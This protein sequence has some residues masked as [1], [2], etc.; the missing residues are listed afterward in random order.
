M[1]KKKIALIVVI[2]VVAVIGAYRIIEALAPA[3]VAE[4]APVNVMVATAELGSINTTSLITGRI[5][6]VDEAVVVPLVAGEVSSVN[7]SLGDY[8][9]QGAVL[10]TI[11]STTASS[12]YTQARTAYDL[13]ASG[14]ETARTNLERITVLY[15]E[16][17]VSLAEYE[18]AQNAYTQASLSMEQARSG[19]S[20]A[21]DALGYYTVTAPISG[22]ITSV[23]VSAGSLA[24]QSAAAVT[25]ADTSR[26]QMSV[27]VA[28]YL[29]GNLQTGDPVDIYISTLSEE[30]FQGTISA[31]APAPATGSLTYPATI[32]VDNPDG[33]IMAGMFAE[34][35]FISESRENVL[36]IPSDAVFMKSGLSMVAVLEDGLPVLKEV[37]TGID[38]GEMV[39]ITGGLSPGETIITQGQQYVTE[40]QPVNIIE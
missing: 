20:A 12:S 22:Y 23:N 19:L 27:S 2:A 38:D 3:E 25:M 32:S 21:S 18:G 13:A 5:E 39:E 24:G 7:V 9:E 15:Q 28:E 33:S 29:V 6:A 26:L 11:D 36:C 35:R 31:L 34:V 14:L 4:Q 30:P 37:T 1:S 16:G 40:G 17:A 10:F 8:V